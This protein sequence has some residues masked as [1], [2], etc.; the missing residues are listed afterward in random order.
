MSIDEPT[1]KPIQ[2]TKLKDISK[3]NLNEHRRT[4]ASNNKKDYE[5]YHDELLM[6]Q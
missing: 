3:Y 1:T 5:K 6:S 4:S 2:K